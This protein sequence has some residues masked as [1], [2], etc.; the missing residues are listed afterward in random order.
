[1]DLEFW[2]QL[3]ITQTATAAVS[4]VS[5][6]TLA[7]CVVFRSEPGAA[8]PSQSNG[9]RFLTCHGLSNP[10][11]R[12]IFGLSVSD[13]TQSF[14]I[15][16]GP[17]LTVEGTYLAPWGKGNIHTCR[18][19]GLLLAIGYSAVPMYTFFI[20]VYYLCKLKWKMSNDAFTQRIE[21]KGHFIII[22]SN[23]VVY[24]T[25]LCLDV[26]NTSAF[27]TVCYT[28]RRPTGCQVRPDVFGECEEDNSVFFFSIFNG[29][30]SPLVC[31]LGCVGCICMIM[32]HVTVREKMFKAPNAQSSCGGNQPTDQFPVRSNISTQLHDQP[33]AEES[34]VEVSK[35]KRLDSESYDR[36][37]DLKETTGNISG[38][39]PTD[40]FAGEHKEEVSV[41]GITE[42]NNDTEVSQLRAIALLASVK[43]DSC[44]LSDNDDQVPNPNE[45]KVEQLDDAESGVDPE[46]RPLGQ[47]R[48]GDSAAILRVYK[49]ELVIQ[50]FCYVVNFCITSIPF[51]IS[52]FLLLLNWPVPRLLA[53]FLVVFFPLGGFLNILAFTRPNVASVRRKN[54]RMSR[55]QA[56]WLVLKAGGEVPDTNEYSPIVRN[57]Q[58]IVL[59]LTEGNR[60]GDEWKSEE[61]MMLAS[62]ALGIDGLSQSLDS[63]NAA[64]R[65]EKDW[66]H[67]EGEGSRMNIIME[68]NSF[69]STS[70]EVRR[71]T[72]AHVSNSSS[73]PLPK[74]EVDS[75][76]GIWADAFHRASK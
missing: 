69:S 60:Q 18:F 30:F 33:Q 65:H 72:Q 41:F 16:A 44:H 24:F 1:M 2:K 76:E 39:T 14:A 35:I 55:L 61:P 21:K 13:M 56:L 29:L 34:V 68:S 58:A 28:A 8:P 53:M 20:S 15:L 66:V 74:S 12:I 50:V 48:A 23:L 25:A 62:M 70:S 38:G 45:G 22:S 11:R 57:R 36:I 49:R 54:P 4:L 42:D 17:W 63:K 67:E 10:Y 6:S 59:S 71:S 51:M 7:A 52:S 73:I 47:S 3:A 5:S 26:F 32:W 75:L 37:D 27:G 31:I 40:I 19:G 46:E 64:Y 43:S 9:K